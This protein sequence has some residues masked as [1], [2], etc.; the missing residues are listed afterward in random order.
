MGFRW[1]GLQIATQNP[2][3]M[4]PM[5]TLLTSAV[6]ITRTAFSLLAS[7]WRSDPLRYTSAVAMRNTRKEIC[8]HIGTHRDV[9]APGTGTDSQAKKWILNGHSKFHGHSPDV[10]TGKASRSW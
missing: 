7:D 8:D 2:T 3:G 10:A 4:F 9:P 1:F 6:A 5:V